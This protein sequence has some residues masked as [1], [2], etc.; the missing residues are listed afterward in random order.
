MPL[1]SSPLSF[2]RNGRKG[3]VFESGSRRYE[4]ESFKYTIEKEGACANLKVA[5]VGD[6]RVEFLSECTRSV[7][8]QPMAK[9]SC[10]KM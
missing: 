4:S 7:M 1:R 10:L 6:V 3:K 5:N 2:R 9:K 8:V